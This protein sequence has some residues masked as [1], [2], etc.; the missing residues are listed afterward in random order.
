MKN[1]VKQNPSQSKLLIPASEPA[2]SRAMADAAGALG[3]AAPSSVAAHSADILTYGL[4][5]KVAVA[6]F[7]KRRRR[8]ARILNARTVPIIAI[9]LEFMLVAAAIFAAGDAYHMA[10]VGYLP[11]ASE[12]LVATLLLAAIFVVPCGLNRDYSISRLPQG[13]EQLRSVFLHWNTAYLLFAFTL[14]IS[15]ATEFYSR[16][17]IVAQYVAGILA[18]LALR[19]VLGRLIAWGLQRGAL[20]GKRI[21]VVGDAASVAYITRRL[22]VDAR[23][24]DVVGTVKLP[25]VER[26]THGRA[27]EAGQD[28]QG[29][30]AAVEEIARGTELDEVVLSLPWSD[31]ARIRTFVEELSVVPA[32]IHLAP[33]ASAAWAHHLSS[34]GVGSLPTLKLSRAPLTLR[35]RILKRIFD[36]AVGSVFLAVALPIFVVIGLMIKLD[37]KGPVFFRQRRHGFNQGE[38]RIFKFRTMTTLDDGHLVRQATRDDKRITRVGR[39]LRRTNLDELPQLINVLTGQ[40]SL[41]GPRPHAVAHNHEFEE[42]IRLYAKRHNVKPGISG[43][44]Q[45]NGY[46]GETEKLEKM[47]KRVEFDVYYIDNWSLL[48]DILILFMTIF[49]LKSYKNAY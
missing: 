19:L 42:K 12:Y 17:S 5:G 48:F 47:Q 11:N 25:S 10:I 9:A 49:S 31:P 21:I 44:S 28:L 24:V 14:F 18:A 22:R 32:T 26:G 6:N 43:W 4:P 34:A 8:L 39:F 35:D 36:L 23:G 45:I 37:S 1:P 2:N 46:R 27:G 20:G 33:D 13:R 7:S 38:F 30:L 40:M 3:D 16:G 41:V 29:A 15:H